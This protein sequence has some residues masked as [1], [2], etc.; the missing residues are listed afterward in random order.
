MKLEHL[1]DLRLTVD[2]DRFLHCARSKSN[3]W[4]ILEALFS[5]EEVAES[6]LEP[7]G[8]RVTLVDEFLRI[9]RGDG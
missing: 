5:G 4:Y 2:P 9:E 1:T 7:W 3:L 6:E 8:L